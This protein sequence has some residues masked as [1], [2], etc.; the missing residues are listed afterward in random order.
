MQF[1]HAA[2]IVV[3]HEELRKGMVYMEKKTIGS[4]IATL[5]KAN[6]MTQKELAEKLNV[7]DK[8]VSR[9]EREDGV[10]DLSVIPVIAEIFGVTCDELLRG[11]RSPQNQQRK[12]TDGSEQEIG[13]K[14]E[15][16]RRRI[17]K[18][19]LSKYKT[20]TFVTMGISLLGLIVAMIGNLVFLRAY[21][22][23]YSGAVLYLAGVICQA[24]FVN[25]AFLAVDNE[26]GQ[27]GEVG[28][29]R[30]KVV[31]LA[32]YA[33]GLTLTLFAATFPLVMLINDTYMGLSGESWVLYGA[34]FG[35]VTLVVV[36]VIC[37]IIN[38]KLFQK[39]IYFPGEKEEKQ[40][41]HNSS[42]VRK[43]TLVT[44]L[45]LVG[46]VLLHNIVTAGGNAHALSEGTQYYDYESFAEFMARP[47]AR[48]YY[49]GMV[50]I[51]EEVVP[52]SGTYY[53]EHGNVISEEEALTREL[54]DHKGNVVFS[55]V[56]RNENVCSVRYTEKDGDFLPITVITYDDLQIGRSKL[57]TANTVFGILYCGEVLLG[58]F[59][60]C[61]KRH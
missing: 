41:R 9:W 35:G 15:K 49:N 48:S 11:E 22:G 54:R 8:T 33:I 59:I 24:I 40:Y 3:K 14:G 26:E 25:H 44:G 16:Q 42:L 18:A 12:V 19:G 36:C 5:R 56:Q 34:C 52:G 6:G 10:P 38:R 58:I 13:A 60:Y 50:M 32:E 43:C 45:I 21:A 39:A 47:E 57:E 55:Y 7:S 28:A 1:I 29:F 61:K 51:A 37:H 31:V 53:D 46:T 2:G 20:R 17:L 23:F 30:R 27:G 4:F